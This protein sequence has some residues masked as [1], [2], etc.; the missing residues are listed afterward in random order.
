MFLR[1][2]NVSP[3]TIAGAGNMRQSTDGTGTPSV[4]GVPSSI[5]FGGS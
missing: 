1:K 4:A 2:A 5:G 3:R